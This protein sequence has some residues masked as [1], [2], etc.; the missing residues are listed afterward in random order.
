LVNFL[1]RVKV[2][3]AGVAVAEKII[4]QFEGEDTRVGWCKTGY[5]MRSPLKKGCWALVSTSPAII[6]AEF[7]EVLIDPNEILKV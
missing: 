1:S 2:R 6:V 4:H 7:G 5:A 3:S